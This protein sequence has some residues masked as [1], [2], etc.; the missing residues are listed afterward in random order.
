MA[1]VFAHG[2]SY[3]TTKLLLLGLAIGDGA[4]QNLKNALVKK[5]PNCAFCI[6]PFLG[7]NIMVY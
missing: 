6:L 1:E 2:D 3:I 4:T 5:F 7:L